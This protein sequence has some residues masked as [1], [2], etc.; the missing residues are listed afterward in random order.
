VPYDYIAVAL[1]V[2]GLA[3]RLTQRRQGG[4]GTVYRDFIYL[5]TDRLQSIIAQ[6]QEGLLDQVVEGKNEEVSGGTRL[7]ANLLSLLIPFSASASVGYKNVTDL[8]Q[9]KV[10]HDYAFNV[11]LDAMREQGFLLE[12]DL[13]SIPET[14]F[15]L[16][17]GFVRIFDYETISNMAENWNELDEFFNPPQSKNERDKRRKSEQNRNIGQMKVFTDVFFKDAI[18]VRLINSEDHSFVGPLAREHLREEMRNLIFKHGSNPSDEW[19]MLAEISRVPLLGNSPLGRLQKLME[20]ERQLGDGQQKN[21]AELL[22]FLLEAFD[23]LQEAIG[24]ASPFDVYVS[25]VAIYRE[26]HPH[27]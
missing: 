15:V 24:S 3:E 25:P 12:D 18:R 8:K 2:G 23:T 21:P 22:N 1:V 19:T 27:M 7:T 26:I 20:A 14:G 9:N 16:V 5:D 4:R 11:A 6:L 13:N 10:L 17:E